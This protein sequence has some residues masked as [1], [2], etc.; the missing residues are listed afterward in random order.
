MNSSYIYRNWK[1]NQ[2][3][4]IFR[5]YGGQAPTHHSNKDEQRWKF[6]NQVWPIIRY[7]IAAYRFNPAY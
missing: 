6:L 5:P 7:L 1:I 3:F 4:K 2:N